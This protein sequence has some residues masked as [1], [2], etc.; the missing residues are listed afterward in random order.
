MVWEAMRI[1]IPDVLSRL[2][3]LD[4]MVANK[5]TNVKHQKNRTD[6]FSLS[7]PY[8]PLE[9]CVSLILKP[10]QAKTEY[11]RVGVFILSLVFLLST[12][13][14]VVHAE[15][16]QKQKTEATQTEDNTLSIRAVATPELTLQKT[17]QLAKQ[18]Y[19]AIRRVQAELEQAWAGIGVSKTAYLPTL[20]LFVQN[21][22][23]TYNKL[24][25][26]F[27]PQAGI[28]P[29]AGPSPHNQ[30]NQFIS[31][32]YSGALLSWNA[33]D[34]GFRHAQVE[35]A[36]IGVTVAAANKAL[37]ELDVLYQAAS[38]YLGV[39][40]AERVVKASEAN[41]RRMT[42]FLDN[43]AVLVKSGLRPGVDQ[44]R[45]V[46]D[47][48]SA[49]THLIQS[50]QQLEID[51][52]ILAQ[53]IG[54]AGTPVSIASQPFL[55]F[56]PLLPDEVAQIN[57]TQNNVE[58]H[59]SLIL[60]KQKVA[61]IQ[62]QERTLKK[63][64][65]PKLQIMGGLNGRG[66]QLNAE[67]QTVTFGRGVMPTRINY[68]IAA[69]LIFN[70]FDIL[71]ERITMR[72]VRFQEAVERNRTDEISQQLKSALAQAKAQLEGAVQVARNTPLAVTAA[73]QTEMQSKARYKAGLATLLDV[74]DAQRMLVNAQ[75]DDALAK[76]G[77][78]KSILEAAKARG[79]I[80]PFVKM[81]QLTQASPPLQPTPASVS[82]GS[83]PAPST[84]HP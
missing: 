84:G 50:Q 3:K 58:L 61:V 5:F 68:G 39:Q 22:V 71:T 33:Y 24:P 8:L 51:R 36:K 72:Q 28:L 60:Q 79:D 14:S 10:F 70:P 23:A 80:D 12:V 43:V 66:S 37:T 34:F 45:A 19:P 52:A 57:A 18:N 21:N 25:G 63:S 56:V 46:A 31:G 47:L 67:S 76:L 78:W 20:N 83:S 26:L 49:R 77:V 42:V 55:D 6:N 29:V 35:Q 13:A 11:H 1:S 30:N 9:P 4:G 27:F 32:E 65:M 59:P 74:A 64:Y 82:P 41:V 17:L 44:S 16:L 73:K 75:I 69:D 7:L 38:A 40:T 62:A 81:T 15:E 2:K 53:A 48:A 54:Q